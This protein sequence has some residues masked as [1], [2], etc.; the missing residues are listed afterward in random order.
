MNSAIQ[1]LYTQIPSTYEL[2]NH[3]L[4]FGMDIW[5]RRSAIKKIENQYGVRWLDVCTGTG[6]TAANLSK[7][8]NNGNQV[9]ATDFSL[10]MISLAKKKPEGNRIKF[11]ISEIK[12]LPFP[13]NTFDL[14]TI[15]FATRNIDINRQILIQSFTEIRRVL[16]S[17]GQFINLETSQPKSLFIRYFFHLYVKIFIRPIGK[18]VSGS[19]SAYTY[20]ASTIPKFYHA[21]ELKQIIIE[22]G[23][24]TVEYQHLL[25]GAAAIHSSIK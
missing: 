7:Q 4:T 21:E 20:L 9:F 18:A 6:E 2:V 23:F 25:F 5:W 19:K 8:A 15:S 1:K 14:I 24:Q 11:S 3:L 13:D 17:G 16:K 10:P 12:N 22:S